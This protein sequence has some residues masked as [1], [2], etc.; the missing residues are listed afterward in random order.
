MVRSISS[1]M[2]MKLH[3]DIVDFDFDVVEIRVTDR[4]Y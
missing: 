2:T 3:N 4:A 1:P